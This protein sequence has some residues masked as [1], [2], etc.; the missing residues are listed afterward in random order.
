MTINKF[1]AS[2]LYQMRAGNSYL[3]A[4]KDWRNPEASV[5]CPGCENE[6]ETFEHVIAGCQALAGAR[7]GQPD[8]IFDISPESLIWAENKKGWDLM[9]CL[10][11]FISLN[12]IN[13]PSNMDVHIDFIPLGI[14]GFVYDF[15]SFVE[16]CFGFLFA[17]G[18]FPNAVVGPWGVLVMYLKSYQGFNKKKK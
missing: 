2:R 18:F 4:Q 16:F 15:I 1:A 9:K 5:L 8:E 6:P 13:F 11:S 12:K 7:V 3:K 17:M 10:V 14:F